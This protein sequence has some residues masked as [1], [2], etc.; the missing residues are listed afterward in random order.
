[1][2]CSARPTAAAFVAALVCGHVPCAAGDATTPQTTG[3]PAAPAPPAVPA[4]PLAGPRVG[5]DAGAG[6]EGMSDGI[7]KGAP[8][9]RFVVER[10]NVELWRR[11]FEDIQPELSPEVQ[12]QVRDARAS[13]EARM[14]AWREANGDKVAALEKKARERMQGEGEGKKGDGTL[15]K[16]AQELRASA[17]KV[18]ELQQVVW[19]LLTPAQQ[20]RFK[21]RYDALKQEAARRAA[22]R[23]DGKKPSAPADPM[24]ADPMLPGGGSPD[25]HPTGKPFNFEDGP[26]QPG[27]ASA[28]T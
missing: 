19:N 15:L 18:E 7:G 13:F 10:R 16:Q 26:K 8:R 11:A 22:E 9:A 5:E 4:P 3:T 12:V 2:T 28:P 20:E 27:G 25:R 17:P 6:T 1:M 24:Q 23:K 21:Q 14:K